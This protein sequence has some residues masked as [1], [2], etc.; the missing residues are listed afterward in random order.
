MVTKACTEQKVL[1]RIHKDHMSNPELSCSCNDDH[2]VSDQSGKPA[3]EL[4][5]S[6]VLRQADPKT[7]KGCHQR[8][9]LKVSEN[10]HLRS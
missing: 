7:Q 3:K 6:L 5:P 10:S 4:L 2:E 1:A 9:V 8:Q